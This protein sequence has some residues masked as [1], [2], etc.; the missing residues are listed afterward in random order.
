[1]IFKIYNSDFG[2]KLGGVNYSFTHVENMSIEDPETTKL[3]RG[4]NA[5][6]KL[7]LP[8]KEGIKEPK[9]VTVT[10][11]GMSKSLKEVLD[12][13]YVGQTRVDVWCIDRTDG[14]SKMAKNAILS[15]QPNQLTIDENSDSMNVALIFE[16]YDVTETHKS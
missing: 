5:G 13:A 2:I 14:S 4:A 3:V 15:T 8:Y 11:K 16:S 6:D 9:K 10:I 7:G 12:A 1:M